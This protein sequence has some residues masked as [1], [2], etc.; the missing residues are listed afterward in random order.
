[1]A[2]SIKNRRLLSS[3]TLAAVVVSCLLIGLKGW[4]WRQTGSSAVHASLMDSFLDAIA[5]LLNFWAL[6]HALIPPDKEHRFGHGKIE[7]LASLGQACF[8][9]VSAIWIL[10]ECLHPLSHAGTSDPKM[11]AI[12]AISF[13]LTGGLILWQR[14][15]IR[16]TQSLVIQSDSLHYEGD[17]LINAGACLGIY[18]L[19]NPIYA[20]ADVAI[21][22]VVALYILRSSWSIGKKALDILMD[23]ELPDDV[24]DT[25]QSIVL[26]HPRVENIHDLR[27]RSSGFRDFIQLHIGL[28]GHITLKEAHCISDDVELS[29]HQR[30]PHADILIHQDPSSEPI[31]DEITPGLVVEK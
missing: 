22:C 7:A 13:P 14:F 30:F 29:L 24:I 1:M 26:S 28:D 16:R 11:I 10:S 2:T 8:I 21:G 17:L 31:H 3:A 18:A 27:T 5:S 9:A 6:R 19:G 23:R 15:V 25:I 20:I 12:L 4:V